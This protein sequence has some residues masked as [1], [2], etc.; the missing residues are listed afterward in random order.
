M[1]AIIQRTNTRASVTANN[2]VSGEIDKGLIVYLGIE[3]EDSHED[4]NWLSRK[5]VNMRIF[6]DN[7][8]KMNMSLLDIN[9]SLLV[10]SQFTLYASTKKGN[11]PSFIRSARPPFAEHMYKSF[12]EHIREEYN[13]NVAEGVFGADMKVSY[14]NDGPVSI[15]IDTKNKE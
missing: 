13:I 12:C 4:I 15:F 11:R 5:I 6:S 1:R 14:V 3:E 2:S 9:G 8:G 10:I 7:E